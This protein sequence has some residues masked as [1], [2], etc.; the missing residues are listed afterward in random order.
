MPLVIKDLWQYLA[1]N[2]EGELLYEVTRKGVI[3]IARH[4][5]YETVRIYKAD[6]NIRN[7]IRG[8]LNITRAT[9]YRPERLAL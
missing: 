6:N 9:N 4:Y 2:K 7:I 8:G 3:N 1:R 5:Y